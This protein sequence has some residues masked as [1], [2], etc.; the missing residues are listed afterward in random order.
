MAL[1][2]ARPQTPQG[3]SGQVRRFA[4]PMRTATRHRFALFQDLHRMLDGGP[5]SGLF[6]EI[7]PRYTAAGK[8]LTGGEALMRWRRADGRLVPPAEFIPVAEETGMI[9]GL[10]DRLLEQVA[11]L[12]P[13]LAPGQRI[14]INLPPVCLANGHFAA[15]L[16]ERLAHC[17]TSGDRL[18]IEVT[19]GALAGEAAPV[20]RNLMALRRIGCH[21]AI[22]DFGTGYSSLSRLRDLP[23][24]EL[25]IDRSFVR[26][27]A[28]S[29]RGADFLRA[30][31][32]MGQAL[33]LHLVAEGVE[34]EAELAMVRQ[35]GCHEVQGWLW[36]RA[37]PVEHFLALPAA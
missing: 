2:E 29:P 23:I 37:M 3:T 21:I 10:T 9:R 24:D 35:V 36:G 14:G 8:V 1:L 5:E 33:G 22:D 4:A 7:Q 34:T 30:I 28:T 18:V 12:L 6:V 32:A 25:K 15:R 16:E 17:R 11:P 26:A 19:E 31:A 13:K 27:A 20:E